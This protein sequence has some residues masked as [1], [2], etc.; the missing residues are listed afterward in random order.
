MQLD[1]YDDVY[2][3][4]LDGINQTGGEIYRYDPKTG[5]MT[6]YP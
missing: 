5:V 2:L 3:I 1:R 4:V 6:E